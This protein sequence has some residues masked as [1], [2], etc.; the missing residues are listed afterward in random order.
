MSILIGQSSSLKLARCRRNPSSHAECVSVQPMHIG[1]LSL[2][3]YGSIANPSF[4]RGMWESPQADRL[5]RGLLVATARFMPCV[6][7]T[8]GVCIESEVAGAG[9]VMA[10]PCRMGAELKAH[11]FPLKDVAKCGIFGRFS[12]ITAEFLYN[13]PWV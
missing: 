7:V 5:H 9:V 11:A 3:L 4:L 8:L 2:R 10:S 13:T 12:C 1:A 6:P